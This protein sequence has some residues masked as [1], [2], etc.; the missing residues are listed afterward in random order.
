MQILTVRRFADHIMVVMC[1]A[2]RQSLS[3]LT[4][5]LDATPVLRSRPRTPIQTGTDFGGKVNS[6]K[7]SAKYVRMQDMPTL[8]QNEQRRLQVA[9]VPRL[10]R[11]GH[12]RT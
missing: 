4:R 6:P 12:R 5:R 7:R 2:G 11:H 8:N 1:A 3:N 9:T 10:A